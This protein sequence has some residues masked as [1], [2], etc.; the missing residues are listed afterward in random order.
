MEWIIDVNC[1]TVMIITIDWLGQMYANSGWE[2]QQFFEPNQG[3]DI[4]TWLGGLAVLGFEV[5][6]AVVICCPRVA[7][8]FVG[9]LWLTKC[10]L[11]DPFIGLPVALDVEIKQTMF[12]LVLMVKL[13]VG[14]KCV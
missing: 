9:L 13:A 10:F 8:L 6:L 12:C 5:T 7:P 3:D 2:P 4:C 11:G 1:D 14:A